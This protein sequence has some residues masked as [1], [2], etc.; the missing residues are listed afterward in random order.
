MKPVLRTLIFALAILIA[1]CGSENAPS[2]TMPSATKAI[3]VDACALL[4]H[5]EI[6][7]RIGKVPGTP[8]A[9]MF[10][11]IPTCTWPSADGSELQILHVS[12]A[13]RAT[14][15]YDTFLEEQQAAWGEDYSAGDYELFDVGDFAVRQDDAI[16][17]VFEGGYQLNIAGSL[18]D[19]LPPDDA[20]TELGRIAASRLP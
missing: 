1:A 2:D 8:E 18:R 7:T 17:Y 14:A 12:V 9:A 19:G 5:E 11:A 15:D 6:E 4:T 20:C 3:Q 16:F 10:G 13:R